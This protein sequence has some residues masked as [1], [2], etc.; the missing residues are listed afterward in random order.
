MSI[1]AGIVTI[2]DDFKDGKI[3]GTEASFHALREY[4]K[5]RM[6]EQYSHDEIMFILD[7]LEKAFLAKVKK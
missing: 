5:V 3:E 6:I 1:K 7:D 4:F 2:R